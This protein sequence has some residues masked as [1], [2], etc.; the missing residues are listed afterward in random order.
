MNF[1]KTNPQVLPWGSV[2]TISIANQEAMSRV[3]DKNQ[4]KSA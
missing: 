1:K 2:A 3:L 4:Y